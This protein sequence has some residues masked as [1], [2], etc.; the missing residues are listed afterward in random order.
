MGWVVFFYFSSI[1]YCVLLIVLIV[2]WFHNTT[3]EIARKYDSDISPSPQTFA[4]WGLIYAFQ[5]AW[6]IYSLT[7]LCRKSKDG[8]LYY[9]PYFMPLSFYLLY[10]VSNACNTSWLFLWD[11][12]YIYASSAILI[13]STVVLMAS[14][15]VQ[16]VSL[17]NTAQELIQQGKS[18][19]LFWVRLLV[20]NGIGMYVTWTVVASLVG[21]S[22]MLIYREPF[23]TQEAASAISASLLSVAVLAYTILD[24]F[25]IDKNTRYLFTPYLVLLW[26]LKGIMDKG[27]FP[28]R[29]YS[30]IVA[31]LLGY[32]VLAFLVKL[33]LVIVR[34][35]KNPEPL[36]S[37]PDHELLKE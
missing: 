28:E 16:V 33:I 14:L 31:V 30:I 26:A 5:L 10:C 12:E 24:V 8:Y 37:H 32:S 35:C 2:G 15:I 1:L 23:L 36:N 11:R 7:L 13:A 19:E 27:F 17:A 22:I 6:I 4:I 34:S 20:H 9:T 18:R 29:T 3:G 21:L 25:I